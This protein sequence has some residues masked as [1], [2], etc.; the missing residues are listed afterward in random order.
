ME[1]IQVQA[2]EG[3]LDDGLQGSRPIAF[4]LLPAAYKKTD[5]S[6]VIDP[7]NIFQTNLADGGITLIDPETNIR[8]HRSSIGFCFREVLQYGWIMQYLR[9]IRIRF[10]VSNQLKS[11]FFNSMYRIDLIMLFFRDL[12]ATPCSY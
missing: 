2:F 4:C 11:L 9:N 1:P 7:F 5:L 8:W 12:S 6:L 10:F 3:I